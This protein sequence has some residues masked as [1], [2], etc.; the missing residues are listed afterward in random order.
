MIIE[1]AS[2]LNECLCMATTYAVAGGGAGAGIH[3]ENSG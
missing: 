2:T 3:L 1:S